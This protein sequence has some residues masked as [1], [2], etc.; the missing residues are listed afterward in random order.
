MRILTISDKV[1]PVLYGEHIRERVGFVDLV[2]A[3]GDLPYY[4]LEYIVSS[5]DA[6]LYYVHGNHD[7]PVNPAT[8]I[9]FTNRE[10]E[11]L[12]PGT[13]TPFEWAT[14]LHERT[15][16]YR[17]LLLAGLEGCRVYNPGARY[18]YS[19]LEVARQAFWLGWRL[20]LNRLKYGRYLDVLITHSPPFGIHDARDVAHTGFYTY[21]DLLRRYRPALMIHGH[22]HVYSRL[23]VT[24]SV[25][26]Q[27]RI[28]NTYPYRIIE[29]AQSTDGRWQVVNTKL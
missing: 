16:E 8:A 14:N 19:E 2:L 7:V 22:H 23:T 25:Y 10:L 6:P 12:R 15:A 28:V 4:Y 11:P 18:Q 9:D 29:L 3:C 27:T 13:V 5:L 17:G 21:L 1:E 24:D 20:R 26:H